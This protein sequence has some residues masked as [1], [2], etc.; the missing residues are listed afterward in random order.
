VAYLGRNI[1]L[2]AGRTTVTRSWSLLT[3]AVGLDLGLLAIALL[4]CVLAWPN[5][6]PLIVAFVVTATSIFF[7]LRRRPA[8]FD[9]TV[10]DFVHQVVVRLRR[11]IGIGAKSGADD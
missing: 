4:S 2:L 10:H 5:Q 11:T 9:A 3:R 7:T 6:P 1:M 8:E